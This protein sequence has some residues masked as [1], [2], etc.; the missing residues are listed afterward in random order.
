MEIDSTGFINQDT[1]LSR[2]SFP[3]PF[4]HDPPNKDFANQLRAVLT[5]V[6]P[7][8]LDVDKQIDE[9]MKKR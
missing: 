4:P 3:K 2:C 9:T 7:T 1:D 8:R 5:E 6:D